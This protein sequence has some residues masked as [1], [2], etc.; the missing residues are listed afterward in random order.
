MS[1]FCG[2]FFFADVLHRAWV[3]HWAGR[4]A[5]AGFPVLLSV[6]GVGE[7]GLVLKGLSHLSEGGPCRHWEP[8]A[9]G[10]NILSAAS[11]PWHSRVNATLLHVSAFAPYTMHCDV[12][13]VVFLATSRRKEGRGG[14][15]GI[16]NLGCQQQGCRGGVHTMPVHIRNAIHAPRM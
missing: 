13:D 10:L 1:P 4:L 15:T 7:V 3:A 6:G 12:F 16:Q 11:F 8:V 2:P 14:R 9:D 5:F